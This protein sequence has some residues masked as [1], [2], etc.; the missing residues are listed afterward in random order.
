[1]TAYD[2]IARYYDLA[3]DLLTDDIDYVVGLATDAGGPVLEL[4]CGSGRLLLPLARAGLSVTGVDSSAAMLRLAE[5]R[6]ATEDAAAA[7]RVRLI[8]GDIA[9]FA[10]EGE[11]FGLAVFGYNT[12][13]HLSETEI[14]AALRHIRGC[15]RPGGLLLIDI[16]N[17]FTLSTDDGGE[18]RLEAEFGTDEQPIRQY[19]A[20]RDVPGEQAVDVTWLY[21]E[22]MPDGTTARAESRFRQYLYYPHQIDLFLTQAGFRLAGLG[23]GY[24]GEGYDEESERLLALGSAV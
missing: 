5:A 3:H 11:P 24:E 9:A 8:E 7:A 19:A 16:E 14:A 1:M 15:L 6:L 23:G 17:P 4:G 2:A 22:T 18:P 21:E 13:M 20:Y 12:F 10:A